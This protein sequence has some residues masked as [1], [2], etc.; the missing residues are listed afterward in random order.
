MA[1]IVA[2]A[3]KLLIA[4]WRMVKTGELPE[5]VRVRPHATAAAA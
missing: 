1:M 5:G 2:L 4:L 3:R